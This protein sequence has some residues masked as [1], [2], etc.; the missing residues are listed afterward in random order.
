MP[1]IRRCNVTK[2]SHFFLKQ[3]THFKV[4]SLESKPYVMGMKPKSDA[5][6]KQF[7]YQGGGAFVGVF[8]AFQ[9]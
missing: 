5:H 1:L 7:E 6:P 9:V 2:N 4:A 8:S 3:G